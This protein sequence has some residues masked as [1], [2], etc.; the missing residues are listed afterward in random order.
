M[1]L[2]NVINR[3]MGKSKNTN[4]TTA[5]PEYRHTFMPKAITTNFVSEIERLKTINDMAYSILIQEEAREVRNYHRGMITA[6]EIIVNEFKQNKDLRNTNT[7]RNVL[8]SMVAFTQ[9]ELVSLDMRTNH[10]KLLKHFIDGKIQGAKV[11]IAMVDSIENM[12][13]HNLI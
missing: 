9:E 3:L 2:G 11:M 7:L 8:V 13:I 10:D 1:I 12:L 4:N 6:Y 5:I